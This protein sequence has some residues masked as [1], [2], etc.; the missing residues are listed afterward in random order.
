MAMYSGACHK[1]KTEAE[2]YSIP[3]PG[4]CDQLSHLD[5]HGYAG[6]CTASRF[7]QP[8]GFSSQPRCSAG[9]NEDGSALRSVPVSPKAPK[10]S[11][12]GSWEGFRAQFE[13]LDAAER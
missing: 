5:G 7:Q 10:F 2:E 12:K 8:E 4:F 3:M 11:G 1:V 13:L 6:E 9:A